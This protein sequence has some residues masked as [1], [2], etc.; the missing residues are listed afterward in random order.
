[1]YEKLREFIQE[2]AANAEKQPDTE[3][4]KIHHKKADQVL[5]A[6][7][8]LLAVDSAQQAFEDEAV[9]DFEA[10]FDEIDSEML[11]IIDRSKRGQQ[12]VSL[13]KSLA[14][15]KNP[16]FRIEANAVIEALELMLSPDY[17]PPL[18]KVLLLEH[19]WALLVYY[20]T[21]PIAAIPR[22][23]D[24]RVDI[25]RGELLKSVYLALPL[26]HDAGKVAS[27]IRRT[28][29]TR[30]AQSDKMGK[31]AA[32][33]FNETKRRTKR[34]PTVPSVTDKINTAFNVLHKDGELKELPQHLKELIKHEEL[35][36]NVFNEWGK[37]PET[38][39]PKVSPNTVRSRL[40]ERKLI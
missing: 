26:K 2:Q 9:Q 28:K 17:E 3:L 4:E 12:N 15:I 33:V 32:T 29:R 34:N 30:Q 35:I 14:A 10:V 22:T 36:R 1:M 21:L 25:A 20:S 23:I 18:S 27:R 40:K 16:P 13:D 24:C 11:T 8:K 5:F 37:D 19:L 38:G 7:Q 31:L 39:I 6:W